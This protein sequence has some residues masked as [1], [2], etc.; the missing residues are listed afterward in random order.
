MIKHISLLYALF[1]PPYNYFVV[2]TTKGV[3]EMSHAL[4]LK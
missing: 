3:T 2:I 4:D 1:T